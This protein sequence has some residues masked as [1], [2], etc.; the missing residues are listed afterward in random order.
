MCVRC[1]HSV[2]ILERLILLTVC[3]TRKRGEQISGAWLDK[4][5]VSVIHALRGQNLGN[6]LD[7]LTALIM[8]LAFNGHNFSDFFF[9]FQTMLTEMIV[10][11]TLSQGTELHRLPGFAGAGQEG[12]REWNPRPAGK[13]TG[14]CGDQDFKF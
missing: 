9:F 13:A 4:L 1:I 8:R 5:S 11:K 2:K 10:C 6:I 14:K 12:Q 3:N 7:V